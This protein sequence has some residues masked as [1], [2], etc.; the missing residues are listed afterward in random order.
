MT[1]SRFRKK[2]FRP[3]SSALTRLVESSIHGQALHSLVTSFQVILI[4]TAV[5]YWIIHPDYSIKHVKF[6]HD[7]FVPSFLSA[8]L[9]YS[10]VF[11]LPLIVYGFAVLLSKKGNSTWS[12]SL[13]IV[14]SASV[15][16]IILVVG[17]I[18]PFLF[19][20]S[21]PYR[22]AGVCQVVIVL[23]KLLSFTTETIISSRQVPSLEKGTS[24]TETSSR[25]L[26]HFLYFLL[27]PTM[28]YRESYPRSNDAI[29]WNFVAQHFLQFLFSAYS[30][31]CMIEFIIEPRFFACQVKI[32]DIPWIVIQS[33]CAAF[34]IICFIAI[35]VLHCCTN[36]QAEVMFFSDRCFYKE[37]WTS[38]N[39]MTLMTSWNV[40]IQDWIFE[41]PYQLLSLKIIGLVVSPLNPWNKFVSSVL[42]FAGSAVVH[43]Y[44]VGVIFG[45]WSP[46]LLITFGLVATLQLISFKVLRALRLTTGHDFLG[47]LLTQTAFL[48][49]WA[50]W[51]VFY[52][53]EHF[54]RITCPLDFDV[55]IDNIFSKQILLKMFVPRS[56]SCVTILS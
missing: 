25:S 5:L 34:I 49:F 56:F 17:T 4:L 23:L 41:Y 16:L 51:V 50:G 40:F 55:T 20:L 24:E 54:S 2:S 18:L 21:I 28:I 30:V 39:A 53:L 48:T 43:D 52:S 44:A 37:Y 10:L 29:R 11:S 12:A 15:C 9:V 13:V 35:G 45:F 32:Q 22:T 47:R 8:I 6:I 38:T 19:D 7:M 46:V 14:I 26:K 36:I 27:A 1:A 3:Q 31:I 42:I 33:F